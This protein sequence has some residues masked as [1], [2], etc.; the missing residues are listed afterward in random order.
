MRILHT[1]DWHIGQTLSGFPRDAE[2]RAFFAHLGRLITE[3]DVDAL[4]IAG[5]VFDGT[6]PSGEAQKLLYTTLAHY[7]HLKPG[8]TI[9]MIAGNHDPAARLEAP[10]AILNALGVH[11]IGAMHQD[12]SRHLIPLKD[13]GGIRAH[14][15]AIPF[16]RP[17]DL[18]GLTLGAVG[19]PE[20]AVVTA[21]RALHADLTAHAGTRSD[22]QLI[23]MGHLTCIGAAESKGAERPIR[24]GGEDAVPP[25][26]YPASIAYVALGHLHKPQSLDNGRVR[27]SGSPFPLSAS[28]ISYDH[29]VTLIE[30]TDTISHR[31]IPVPRTVA[32]I[33]LPTTPVA[34]LPALLDALQLD[35]TTPEDLRPFLY[36]A[37]TPDRPASQLKAEADAL[38]ATYPI[39]VA[40]LTI[41]RQATALPDQPPPSLSETTP[42]DLFLLAF[43]QT[44]NSAAEPAHLAAFRDA[45]AEV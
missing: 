31:H 27:Y 45:M 22:L 13:A 8:L 43:Q 38:L 18:P 37:L 12:R 10:E 24:I 42:E 7:L 36:I 28:E 32:H 19:G 6:N 23:A 11:V 2:H 34:N 26:I 5:D 20:G 30:L 3:H 33:R 41:D 16:L 21:V 1:A 9:V 4:L 14:V 15:L 35:P 39:R 25:D 29:G 40:S 44:H 17:A